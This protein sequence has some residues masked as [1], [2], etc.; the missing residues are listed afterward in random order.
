M[1]HA[2]AHIIKLLNKIT[3]RRQGNTCKVH[4]IHQ[5]TIFFFRSY[6]LLSR[7]IQFYIFPQLITNCRM[8]IL[9]K[10]TCGLPVKEIHF[11]LNLLLKAYCDKKKAICQTFLLKWT[12]RKRFIAYEICPLRTKFP[13]RFNLSRSTNI[14]QETLFSLK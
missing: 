6:K 5:N 4:F 11:F 2:C 3:N 1:N 9:L 8:K 12:L 7:A 14:L 13:G 10:F